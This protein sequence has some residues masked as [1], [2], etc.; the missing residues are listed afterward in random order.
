M[1]VVGIPN[2]DRIRDL[3]PT[4]V[5]AALPYTDS[6]MLKTTGGGE[7]FVLFIEKELMP[8]IDSLYPAQPYKILTGHSFGGL[9]VINVAINH[10]KL[11]NQRLHLYRPKHVVGS[12]EFVK[13]N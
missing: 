3:T 6:L 5:N 11:F 12:N 1:I 4:H 7:R 9:T 2:T 13:Y 8:H 10:T